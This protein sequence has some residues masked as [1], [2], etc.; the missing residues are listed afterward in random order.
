MAA[1]GAGALSTVCKAVGNKCAPHVT[2]F[3]QGAGKSKKAA[4]HDAADKAY[5]Y[6]RTLPGLKLPSGGLTLGVHSAGLA[7]QVQWQ[8]HRAW[9][10][11]QLRG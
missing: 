5:T 9:Q 6:I 1:N 2:Y 10:L 11:F 4:E 3:V 8:G 7:A